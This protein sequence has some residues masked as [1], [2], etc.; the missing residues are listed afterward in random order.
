MRR[1]V[2]SLLVLLLALAGA[3]P[4]WAQERILAY[5]SQVQVNADGSLEVTE[6]IRVRAEG[7]Q[8]RR[9]IF[10][11]FP[12]R[13]RDRHGNRVVVGFEVHEVLRDGRPEPWFTEQVGNGV[14]LNTGNDLLLPT[15]AEFTFTLRYRTTRQL[16]FFAD[17]DELYWNAI[18]TG[19]DFPI[20]AGSVQVRLPQAVAV[21]RLRAEGYTGPQG[22]QRQD[23][24]AESP[25]PGVAEWRLTQP[26]A[27][28]EGLTIVL[29]FPKG[30]I[31]APSGLQKTGWLLRDNRGLLVALA[32]LIV[33]L[34]YCFRRWRQVGRDPSPGIIIVRYEAPAGYSPAGLRYLRRMGYDMRCFSADILSLAVQGALRIQR[35]GSKP[36]DPWVL[37]KIEG[38]PTA[39]LTPAQSAL[40]AGLFKDGST[41]TLELHHRNAATIQRALARHARALK[42][43]FKPAMFR[44]HGGSIAVA[45]GLALL[46]SMAAFIIGAAAGPVVLLV[47]PVALAMF[48]TATTFAF[49]VRAPTPEGRRLLDEIEGLK[50]YLT[51]AEKPDLVR[52]QGPGSEPPL[53]SA[54]FEA[55]LPH[56][57]ALDVEEAWTDRFTQ[58]VG[59]AAAAQATASMAWYRGAPIGD[60]AGFSKALGSSL[61]AQI[62]T[63]SRPPGSSSGGGGGGFSGGGGGGGGGG[64]R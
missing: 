37:Q 57:V 40:L 51:V 61:A 27:P 43:R 50:R 52:L 2:R 35:E 30:I 62:A 26:L 47:I 56:A 36:K 38:A 23:F 17:H 29:S 31:T 34:G 41:T 55:L 19:W 59:A 46:F 3:T 60:V 11:D 49:L 58:A 9:G 12:T 15:P 24:A 8:I 18:G 53:D 20:D 32:G 6:S 22:A 64:G 28:H 63:S 25:Q 5:D 10:R 54:R 48:A 16:G 39:T 45:I 44:T 13:Y 1:L 14:R 7:R 33:L 21:D 4:L 42:Q